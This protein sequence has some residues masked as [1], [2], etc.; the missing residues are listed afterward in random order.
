LRKIL[1]IFILNGKREVI[2]GGAGILAQ[3]LPEGLGRREL[4]FPRV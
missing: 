1:N 4:R 2:T 3:P